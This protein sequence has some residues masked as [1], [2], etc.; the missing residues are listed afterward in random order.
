MR[1]NYLVGGFRT[2]WKVKNGRQGLRRDG[3]LKQGVFE[4]PSFA[5]TFE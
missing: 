2:K 1:V 3:L 5:T 4:W